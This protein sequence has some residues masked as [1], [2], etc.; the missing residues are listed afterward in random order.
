MA[1]ALGIDVGGTDTSASVVRDGGARPIP[2]GTRRLVAPTVV[3]EGANG[4]LLIGEPA[5][6]RGTAEPERTHRG[7]FAA[8]AADCS[9]TVAGAT[10][11]DLTSAMVTH[12]VDTVVSRHGGP[13]ACI[14]LAA[15]A[16]R[17][18]PWRERLAR[19]V[20]HPDV[21]GV[22][23]ATVPVPVAAAA[24]C[25]SR[26]DI[27]IGATLVVVDAGGIGAAATAVV[28]RGPGPAGFEPVATARTDAGG[29]VVMDRCVLAIVDEALG[30][31][32]SALDRRD[33]IAQSALARLVQD[34]REAK[35]LLSG[36]AEVSLPVGLPGVRAAV[37]VSRAEVERRCAA[38][39]TELAAV[40]DDVFARA[41]CTPADA[42]V[43]VV[44]GAAYTPLVRTTV[45]DVIGRRAH[46]PEHAEHAASLGSALIV[47]A[48]L[49]APGGATASMASVVAP[50]VSRP[51]PAAEGP[52]GVPD[53]DEPETLPTSAH[54]PASGH[55]TATDGPG[56]AGSDT[57]GDDRPRAAVGGGDTGRRD[58]ASDDRGLDAARTRARRY[59]SFLHAQR[60]AGSNAGV[61]PGGA[62]TAAPGAFTTTHGRG[63]RR[64]WILIAVVSSAG[65]ALLGGWA[66]G[67]LSPLESDHLPPPRSVIDSHD[68]DEGAAVDRPLDTTP[69]AGCEGVL[70]STTPSACLLGVTVADGHLVVT[71]ISN[72]RFAN[73]GP[74]A[75]TVAADP[76]LVPLLHFDTVRPPQALDAAALDDGAAWVAET[77]TR[78]ED[79]AWIGR[80]RHPAGGADVPGGASR[81][82][83]A[84]YTVAGARTGAGSSCAA[85]PAATG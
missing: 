72:T 18:G 35:E 32:V 24:W 13:P 85:L 6:R 60:A 54:G 16:D 50:S 22:P 38:G 63:L 62:V 17:D 84:V 66:A 78:R 29:G 5:E 41:G 15:P 12:V 20:R 4:A 70:E 49:G 61:A 69:G 67:V 79:G 37:R 7:F 26:S 56:P 42:A 71:S 33:P 28:R 64:A 10:P 34:C 3:F 68:V 43:T 8:L 23:V 36:V 75:T 25:A 73:L 40:V 1:Y 77:A 52:P 44:G 47:A 82:C 39:A 76:A 14:G 80:F 81:I 74:V 59:Q 51:Q 55:R 31:A 21:T 9:V 48:T 83:V 30:G 65:L 11:L 46:V 2:V 27:P 58:D 45:A 19:A 57:P 53:G